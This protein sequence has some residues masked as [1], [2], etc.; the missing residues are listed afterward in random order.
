MY[1]NLLDQIRMQAPGHRTG[2]SCTLHQF[3]FSIAVRYVFGHLDG[4]LY[5]ADPS[6]IRGHVLDDLGSSSIYIDIVFIIFSKS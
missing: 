5:L 4:H 6:W 1:S 2:Q 3:F